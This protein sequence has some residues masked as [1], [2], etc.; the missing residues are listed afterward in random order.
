ML[1]NPA[2]KPD[3]CDKCQGPIFQRDDDREETVK[4]RLM[5]YQSQT[6]PLIEYYRGKGLYTEIDGQQPIDKVLEDIEIGLKGGLFGQ[7]LLRVERDNA[8]RRDWLQVV[9]KNHPH[10]TLDD[11]GEVIV[12]LLVNQTAQKRRSL[13]QALD[14]GVLR[15]S[16]EHRRQ[17][18]MRSGKFGRQLPQ[19]IELA[20]VVSLDHYELT[21]INPSGSMVVLKVTGT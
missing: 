8:G 7:T 14:I 21:F 4:K 5:V 10:Q 15:G 17:C 3:E 19:P 11:F 9:R 2:T 18:G 6:Q 20:L 1:F 13:K 16:A 12:E